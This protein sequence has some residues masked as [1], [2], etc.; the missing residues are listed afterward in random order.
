M[1]RFHAPKAMSVLA[2]AAVATAGLSGFAMAQDAAAPPAPPKFDF[3][4]IDADK[5]GAV[6]KAEAEAYRTT[7][8]TAMDTDKDGKLSAAEIAAHHVAMANA[9]IASRADNR[10]KHMIVDLDTDGDGALTVAEMAAGG[11]GE[12]M[13]DH[14]DADSDG[15]ITQAE[16]DA[17]ADRMGDH[18]GRGGKH[19]GGRGGRGGDHD[20][21]KG[22]FG[23]FW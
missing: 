2:L 7:Q 13:F 9:D 23:G 20:G 18:M 14:L 11:K 16:A 19:G 15:S 12:R 17:A 21:G 3:A 1:T 4:A 10:A 6:T 5:D 22:G 8:I